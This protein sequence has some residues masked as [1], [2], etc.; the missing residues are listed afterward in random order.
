MDE[1][2]LSEL[3]VL[4][5]DRYGPTLTDGDR[6]QRSAVC[7]LPCELYVFGQCKQF[8]STAINR[9]RLYQQA[10]FNELGS[11]GERSHGNPLEV[12]RQYT[13]QES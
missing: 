1:L 12:L 10:V 2:R 11:L 13:V 4:W 7:G 8:S 3:V 6:I 9:E 5:Y